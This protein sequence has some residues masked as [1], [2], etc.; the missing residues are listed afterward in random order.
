MCFYV[1]GV[2]LALDTYFNA[3]QFVSDFVR[4]YSKLLFDYS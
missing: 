1:G 2:I 3:I 4:D